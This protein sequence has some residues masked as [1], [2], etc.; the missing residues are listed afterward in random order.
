ML[1]ENIEKSI[2]IKSSREAIMQFGKVEML[3]GRKGTLIQNTEHEKNV[4]VIFILQET[5]NS[6][7][8]D[9]NCTWENFKC[10]IQHKENWLFIYSSWK[11]LCSHTFK[12][13][14]EEVIV[15]HSEKMKAKYMKQTCRLASRN[16]IT[17]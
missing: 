16:F 5:K 9:K 10:L 3:V 14:S 17:D 12:A 2:V 4:L 7:S 13:S 1:K 15:M 6:N 8:F 11:K